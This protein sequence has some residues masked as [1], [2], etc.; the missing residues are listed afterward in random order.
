MKIK[1]ITAID[2]ANL[3]GSVVE[4]SVSD[5][6]SLT[7]YEEL[8]NSYNKGGSVELP[9]GQYV[10]VLDVLHDWYQL[11][12]WHDGA[13]L[14]TPVTDLVEPDAVTEPST[15]GLDVSVDDLFKD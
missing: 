12:M 10:Y 4:L 6:H 7:D 11:S 15:G 3:H 5:L 9:N 1:L 8:I 14:L 13:K 2:N